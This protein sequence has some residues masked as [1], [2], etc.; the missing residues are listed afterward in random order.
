MDGR[1]GGVRQLAAYVCHFKAWQRQSLSLRCPES[2]F[3]LVE[4]CLVDEGGVDPVVTLVLDG[5]AGEC[6]EDRVT[7]FQTV[8][9]STL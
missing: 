7:F 3:F 9:I 5:L 4:A 1:G 8:P 2:D 6:S